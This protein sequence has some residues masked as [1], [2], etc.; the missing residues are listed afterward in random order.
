MKMGFFGRFRFAVLAALG[1]C[2]CA[3]DNPSGRGMGGAV[4]GGAGD[5][6]TTA[7]SGASG[8]AGSTAGGSSSGGGNLGGSGDDTGSG[9]GGGAGQAAAGAAGTG[10]VGN[11]DGGS[12]DP[13][14]LIALLA[15][16]TA[17]DVP[18]RGPMEAAPNP[19][20]YNGTVPTRPGNGIA[21]HPMLYVGENYN[22]ISMTNQGKV[23]WTYDTQGGF[24]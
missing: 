1:L 6:S 2:A 7:T 20:N 10:G 13:H 8:L 24:E 11:S 14:P 17:P 9:G 22:R 15:K 16:F 12:V 4:P 19:R 3:S 21:Q 5:T 18:A 23:I